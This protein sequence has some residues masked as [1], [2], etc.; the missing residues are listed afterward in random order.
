MKYPSLIPFPKVTHLQV[1]SY[2]ESPP[3]VASMFICVPSYIHR[4]SHAVQLLEPPLCFSEGNSQSERKLTAID[5]FV[6]KSLQ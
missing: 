3:S 2:S 5:W 4:K 1:L 6:E